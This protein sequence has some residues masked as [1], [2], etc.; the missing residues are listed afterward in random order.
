[1]SSFH[2]F[3]LR[4]VLGAIAVTALLAVADA[5]AALA[6][7]GAGNPEDRLTII[8]GLDPWNV[9][10]ER[11]PQWDLENSPPKLEDRAARHREFIQAGVPLEYRSR[12]SPF[13][14][15]PGIIAAGGA[16]YQANCADCHGAKGRGDGD[17]GLDL[18]PSPALLGQLMDRQGAVDEYLLWSIAEGGG[19]FGTAMPAYKE[20]LQEDDIWRVVA[21]MR[22]GFPS[23]E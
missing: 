14:A 7:G 4:A 23:A 5:P 15:S 3:P 22:A 20:T 16:V 9:E 8:P 6:Q 17:A 18:L 11:L 10:I 21:Y 12:R 2:P 13:P 1:M 19:A